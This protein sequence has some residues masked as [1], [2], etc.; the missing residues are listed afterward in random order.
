MQLCKLQKK[1]LMPKFK[2]LCGFENKRKFMA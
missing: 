1:L 2:A